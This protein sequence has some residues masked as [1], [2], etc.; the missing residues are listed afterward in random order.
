MAVKFAITGVLLMILVLISKVQSEHVCYSC[1]HDGKYLCLND[2][3]TLHMEVCPGIPDEF[4]N[5][6]GIKEVCYK[7]FAK[8]R[9]RPR[10][11]ITKGCAVQAD[12][13]DPC[14]E[15]RKVSVVG[16]KALCTVCDMPMCNGT[17]GMQTLYIGLFVM[18]LLNFS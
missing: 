10:Y 18:F 11:L 2:T 8:Q 3:Y 6:S 4:K 7:T 13:F 1:T 16:V 12:K 9:R 15:L 14:T 5:Y 17:K